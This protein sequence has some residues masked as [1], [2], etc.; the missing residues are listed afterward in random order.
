LQDIVT[1]EPKIVSLGTARG[2]QT[3][4]INIPNGIGDGDTVQYQ[5]LAPGGQDLV[6]TFRIKPDNNWQKQGN[7]LVV[8][9]TAVVW[10]LIIGA[11]VPIM[12]IR[13]NKLMLTIPPGTQPGTMLRVRD[14][15][16]P[17]R[18]GKNGDMLV[19][20][21][22]RIPKNISPE[23]IENIRKETKK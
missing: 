4:E 1:P 17:D 18:S 7:N 14:R 11:D 2:T 23:L 19:R 10:D 3:I 13:G 15:G 5:G 9:L 16:M 20:I 8:E 12:D 21:S 6:V 22:V